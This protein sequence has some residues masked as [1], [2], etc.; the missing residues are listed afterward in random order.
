LEGDDG[1]YYTERGGAAIA[2]P[3]RLDLSTGCSLVT[4]T[5]GSPLGAAAASLRRFLLRFLD[6]GLVN[7]VVPEGLDDD[8][9]SSGSESE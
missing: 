2:N 9:E 3:I 7:A 8:G 5:Y 1:R 4:A 6:E